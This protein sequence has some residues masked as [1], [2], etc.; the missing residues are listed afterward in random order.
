MIKQIYL[1]FFFFNFFEECL[2]HLARLSYPAT[3][4]SLHSLSL[5]HVKIW[6]T[7]PTPLFFMR[8][9]PSTS[10]LCRSS[11]HTSTI[12]NS[13]PSVSL[14]PPILSLSFPLSLCEVSTGEIRLSRLWQ[15]QPSLAGALWESI[16][17]ASSSPQVIAHLNPQPLQSFP[18]GC[19]AARWNVFFLSF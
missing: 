11:C 10:C 13:S 16:L 3:F 5:C 4:S 9:R 2:E 12:S 1:S 14:N 15:T 19:L 17:P 8:H 7:Q 6:T 18:P